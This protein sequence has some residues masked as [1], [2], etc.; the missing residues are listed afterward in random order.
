MPNRERLDPHDTRRHPIAR[1][2]SS[3][4]DKPRQDSDTIPP[5]LFAPLPPLPQPKPKDGG[6]DKKRLDGESYR[7]LGSSASRSRFRRSYGAQNEAGSDSGS[8]SGDEGRYRVLRA[9]VSNGGG[10]PI[11]SSPTIPPQ[12]PQPK[13]RSM[14]SLSHRGQSGAESGSDSSDETVAANARSNRSRSG[15]ARSSAGPGRLGESSGSSSTMRSL[16][17]GDGAE[18]AQQQRLEVGCSSDTDNE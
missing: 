15:L 16:A 4:P 12:Y 1:L 11:P 17:R 6:A 10:D 7:S 9:L 2:S 8:D 5:K 18:R 14:R 3:G 13:N